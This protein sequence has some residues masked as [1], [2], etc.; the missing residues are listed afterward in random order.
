MKNIDSIPNQDKLILADFYG[1]WCGPC[2][3]IEPVLNEMETERD[4]V[5][6]V[7]IDTGDCF[8]LANDYK[9]T[10][11]PTLVIIKNG[12]EIDRMVGECTE[13]TI[14]QWIDKFK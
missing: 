5:E 2:A 13:D 4:D 10:S 9:I 11:I 8:E 6:F 7:K 1:E 14:S 3:A 12:K